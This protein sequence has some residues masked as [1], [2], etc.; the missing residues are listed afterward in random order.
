MSRLVL[1]ACLV[2]LCVSS[3]FAQ[4]ELY[5]KGPYTR[6]GITV[7]F[8]VKLTDP[9]VTV[10]NY[11][12]VLYTNDGV[13]IKTID[14]L[15]GTTASTYAYKP[16]QVGEIPANPV[17]QLAVTLTLLNKF[18]PTP[19]KVTRV[20]PIEFMESI[21]A[22]VEGDGKG[23]IFITPLTRT[24][25]RREQ[26][27]FAVTQF[28]PLTTSAALM[29]IGSNGD[30][31]KKV[32]KNGAP[33]ISFLDV[34]ALDFD[35]NSWP[36]GVRVRANVAYKDSPAGGYVQDLIIPDSIPVAVVT[37]SKGFGPFR[38]GVDA[39]NTFTAKGLG[40][41]CTAVEFAI[42]YKTDDGQVHTPVRDTIAY[43]PA[44]DS[45][46]F[47]YNMRDVTMGSVLSVRGVFEVLFPT[48]TPC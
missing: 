38:R 26:G 39:V 47:T 29:L 41:A 37:A 13:T 4:F 20:F 11:R 43:D 3:A 7:P 2:M 18:S 35:F 27:A 17:P 34:L 12:W 40:P 14:T 15:E 8:G 30:T 36:G 48:I 16:L 44:K 1:V 46:V 31:L 28:P 45:A 6:F 9:N 32:T 10:Q 19:Y 23:G 5:P 22:L 25:G 21:F 42:Q 24:L 33:Y